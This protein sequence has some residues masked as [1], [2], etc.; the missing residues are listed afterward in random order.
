MAR[1]AAAPR[2]R[3]AR[4]RALVETIDALVAET[5]NLRAAARRLLVHVN[6]LR[7]RM[8]RAA[9]ISGRSLED[10]EVRLGLGLALRAWAL[11]GT[12]E[13]PP[14]DTGDQSQTSDTYPSRAAGSYAAGRA[15]D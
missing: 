6:T 10:P 8:E 9:R 12:L 4:R 15:D 3:R 5:W 2:R 7:Y 11:L 13:E 14:E 1:V